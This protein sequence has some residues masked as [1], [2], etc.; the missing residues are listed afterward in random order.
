MGML[1]RKGAGTA[2]HIEANSLWLHD[3]VRTGEVHLGKVHT[4]DNSA[5]L[6]TKHLGQELMEK[7]LAKMGTVKV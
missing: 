3:K 1:S 7:H 6:L 4:R 5:D 2:K